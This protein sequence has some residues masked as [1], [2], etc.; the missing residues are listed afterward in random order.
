MHLAPRARLLLARHPIVYWLLVTGLAL[1]IAAMARNRL[2]AVDRA[3]QRWG[4]PAT[5]LIATTDM[6]P[7]DV[8]DLR[9]VDLPAIAIPDDAVDELASDAVVRRH[10][11]SGEVLV[12][13]DLTVG[14]GPAAHAHAGT[15]IVGISDPLAPLDEVGVDVSIVAEGVV[16][17]ERATV[18]AQAGEVTFVAVPVTDAPAVAAAAQTRVAALVFLP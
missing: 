1:L 14:R 7:G 11:S 16:L 2:E 5:V 3:R 9:R 17:A 15:A 13:A 18:V 8:P 6:A 12:A 10:V 4:D